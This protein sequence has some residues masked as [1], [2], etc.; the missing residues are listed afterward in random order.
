M[1]ILDALHE[2]QVSTIFKLQ[3]YAL[4]PHM[5]DHQRKP[6]F[7]SVLAKYLYLILTL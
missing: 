3:I 5:P 7:Q 4:A 1:D 6:Y 2:F